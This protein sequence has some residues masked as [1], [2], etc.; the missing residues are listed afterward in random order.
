MKIRSDQYEY[1]NGHQVELLQSGESFFASVEKVI[2]EAEHFIHFQTYIVDEDK[3]GIRIIN[4]LIRA[5]KR[6]VRTYL[7]LDAF[8]TG[9]L[10]KS[11]ID[12][13]ENSGILF[14]FFS[15][16]FTTKGFQL[17]L[18]LH[19]KVIMADGI[20]AIIGGMNFANRYHGTT[21]K[22]EWLDFAVKVRGPECAYILDILK[23][24]WNKTFIPKNE[25][26]LEKILRPV[27][28]TDNVK[29]KVLQNNWYRNKIEILKSYRNAFKSSQSRMIIFASY[30]LPGRNE[31]KLLRNAS[32]R[33]VDI[34]IVLAAQSDA[35]MFERATHFLYDFILRNNIKIFEYLPSNLHAKVATVD[36]KWS[37]IGSYNMNHLSD[38]ASVE[39]NVGILDEG[40]TLQFEERLK[41]IIR[42]DCRQVTFDE[43]NRRRTLFS[44]FRGWYSYQMIRLMMRIMYQM[45]SKKKKSYQAF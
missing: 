8:G 11:F 36:G 39:I 6:G 7:L 27:S 44:R 37:T 38:Y 4:A 23:K 17:S 32:L 42:N 29:L 13:I 19:S 41:N 45:T 21:G 22:K 10:S 28:Y 31:R 34:T 16:T 33:G 5:A 24:L 15:P 30:F 2:D 20:V 14:R 12:S 40:F 9:Y 43:F 18:R 26:S 1:R 3:T 25:R 35:P